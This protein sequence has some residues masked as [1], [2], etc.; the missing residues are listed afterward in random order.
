MQNVQIFLTMPQNVLNILATNFNVLHN[1]FKE[2]IKEI[3]P[4]MVNYSFACAIIFFNMC[5]S[6]YFTMDSDQSRFGNIKNQCIHLF[7]RIEIS[8]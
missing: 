5:M 3:T 6:F 2:M 8:G 1:Y 7:I 4:P